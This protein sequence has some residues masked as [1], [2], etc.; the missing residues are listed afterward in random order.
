M[1]AWHTKSAPGQRRIRGQRG[2]GLTL[3]GRKRATRATTFEYV[4]I[5][6]GFRLFPHDSDK[7]KAPV[8]GYSWTA[9]PACQPS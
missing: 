5:E 8:L 7:N 4:E 6:I 3:V 1:T 2:Y 9:I